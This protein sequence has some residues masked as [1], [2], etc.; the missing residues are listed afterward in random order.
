MLSK[1]LYTQYPILSPLLSCVLA[2]EDLYSLS[3]LIVSHGDLEMLKDFSIL[4]Y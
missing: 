1:H 2:T 4:V 3:H